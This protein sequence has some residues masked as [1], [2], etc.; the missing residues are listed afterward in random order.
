[1]PSSALERAPRQTLSQLRRLQRLAGRVIMRPLGAD[2]QTQRTWTDGRDMEAVAG[3]FIKP[4]DRLSSFE[5]IEIYNRQYWFRLIDVLYEDFPG[6]RAVLG[7]EQ[8]SLLTRA[9]LAKYPSRSYT[10]RNLGRRLPQFLEEEPSWGNPHRRMAQ[11]MAR[12]EWAQ[13]VAFDGPAK[14]PIS[15]A[16][17]ACGDPRRLR[18]SLQPYLTLLEIAYPL[19]KFSL[20]LKKQSLRGEASNAMD[21]HSPARRASRVR[22]PRA[23]RT[24]LAVHRHDNDIYYQRLEPAAYRILTALSGGV[25]LAEA[26]R[27]AGA[28]ATP[29]RLKNWFANWSALGWF[30]KPAGRSSD[31]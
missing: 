3:E 26:C 4:N 17:L 15:P 19:D 29:L 9:Y 22:R 21:E 28:G 18:L 11:D 13:V 20:A 8:F 16:D 30:C 7:D 12:F 2:F 27:L 6:L 1:M 24:F 10:L 14:A 5:R 25:T 31:G 23:R